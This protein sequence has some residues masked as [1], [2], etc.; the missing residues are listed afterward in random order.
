[1]SYETHPAAELFPMLSQDELQSLADDIRARG[2]LDPIVLL[3]DKVLDGRNRFEACRMAGVE[4]KFEPIVLNGTSPTEWVLSK[5]LRRRQ[6]TKSQAAAVAVEALPLLEAEAK[7]RM[8]A[9]KNA[10]PVQ[11]I[12]QGSPMATRSVTQAGDLLGVNRQYVSDAKKLR[13]T[14]P[15]TYEKVKAGDM[16]ISEAKREQKRVERR[17]ELALNFEARTVKKTEV[18][19]AVAEGL[20]QAGKRQA[21]DAFVRDADLCVEALFRAMPDADEV[22]AATAVQGKEL[23]RVAAEL[24]QIARDVRAYKG[25]QK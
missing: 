16:T 9:G 24:E 25:E 6:L 14:A 11:I 19:P 2:Q 10:D 13:E 7:E 23:D 15:E 18:D 20:I 3:D 8:L 22:V 12:E 5:N 1:M 17:D 4:P 21:L